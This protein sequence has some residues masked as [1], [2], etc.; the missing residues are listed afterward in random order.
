MVIKEGEPWLLWPSMVSY[1][2][3]RGDIG[4]TFEG[5]HSFYLEMTFKVLSKEPSKR[6]LFAK[7]PSYLGVDVEGENNR[8]LLIL[9]LKRD[10]TEYCE[11]IM[12][13]EGI[14]WE[15]VTLLF[16]YSKEER[17]V[18]ISVNERPFISYELKEG[19]SLNSG[20]DPHVI[21][22][23]GNFP[24]NGFNLNY[25]SYEIEHLRI[26]RDNEVLGL[27]DFKERTDYKIY[28]FTRNCNFIHKIL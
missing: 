5:S 2:L 17:L 7:L 19:E 10:T 22:G 15:M 20:S 18:K 8:L 9:N 1:G 16:D 13:E 23:A 6:T 24:H 27:Y 4:N 26:S 12:S 11:Y 3:N 25:C 14:G 21:F 28:D